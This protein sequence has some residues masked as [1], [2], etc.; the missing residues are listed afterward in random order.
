MRYSSDS[1]AYLLS[2]HIYVLYV[3]WLFVCVGWLGLAPMV[4]SMNTFYDVSDPVQ[5]QALVDNDPAVAL[6]EAL[7][8]MSPAQIVA[9]A[10]AAPVSALVY[11]A[12]ALP[13]EVLVSVAL[14][15]PVEAMMHAAALLPRE[16]LDTFYAQSPDDAYLYASSFLTAA[17]IDDYVVRNP[18][19]ALKYN[20]GRLS[21]QQVAQC[22]EA[23]T[24]PRRVRL[25]KAFKSGKDSSLAEPNS[26]FD[27]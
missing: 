12:A 3:S 13:R 17:Q 22:R 23:T 6:D 16:V 5:L 1:T 7:P 25:F 21:E 26:S 2:T 4:G 18:A 14:S 8:F 27:R 20:E 11:A 19:A 15:N 9:A 10:T 24:G